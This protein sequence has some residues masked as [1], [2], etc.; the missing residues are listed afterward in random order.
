M[1]NPYTK[2]RPEIAP[3]AIE[4]ISSKIESDPKGFA[5]FRGIPYLKDLEGGIWAFCLNPNKEVFINNW[6]DSSFGIK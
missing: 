3:K 5:V 2:L 1:R 4:I 6:S